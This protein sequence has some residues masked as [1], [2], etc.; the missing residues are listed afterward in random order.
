MI[1]WKEG[2][3]KSCCELLIDGFCAIIKLSRQK[4][5]ENAIFVKNLTCGF[6][7]NIQSILSV[8]LMMND[9]VNVMDII[10]IPPLINDNIVVNIII[11]WYVIA[12]YGNCSEKNIKSKDPSDVETLPLQTD[13]FL[14]W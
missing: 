6:L 7:E 13:G 9:A 5:R 1:F 8:S 3:K 12:I 4:A 2:T 14:R 11:T 10:V